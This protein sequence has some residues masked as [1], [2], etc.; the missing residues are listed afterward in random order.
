MQ[1]QMDDLREQRQAWCEWLEYVRW[2][3]EHRRQEWLGYRESTS[4]RG[5]IETDITED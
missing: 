5:V 4:P 1:L 2:L 3:D